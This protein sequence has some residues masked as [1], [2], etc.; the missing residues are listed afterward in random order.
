MSI[1]FV[2]GKHWSIGLISLG[3]YHFLYV[4]RMFEI[5]VDRKLFGMT[6]V[7]Q[8][9]IHRGGSKLRAPERITLLRYGFAKQSLFNL[10]FFFYL[11]L[12]F[13]NSPLFFIAVK[14]FR[15]LYRLLK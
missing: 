5:A 3:P 14:I 6:K 4:E 10:R 11:H 15:L 2:V 8:E 12:S 7:E 9:T 13:N 1:F